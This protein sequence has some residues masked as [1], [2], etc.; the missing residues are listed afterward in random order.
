MADMR[1]ILKSGGKFFP[2][3]L[4]LLPATE[5][6]PLPRWSGTALSGKSCDL[7]EDT[8]H[9]ITLLTICFS[10]YAEPQV[11]SFRV[12]Y[13]EQY[14]PKTGF[15]LID[16]RP[17]MTRFKWLIFSGLLR[18]SLLQIVPNHLRDTFMVVYRPMELLE[19]LQV[20]NHLGA[21][22]Y[23]ID[24]EGRVRWKASGQANPDELLCFH[25]AVDALAREQA[26]KKP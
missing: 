12:P 7:L 6:T 9:K 26:K 5:A 16:V 18:R 19:P 23:L 21:Y 1:N 4:R 17:L 15:Q 22:V 2:A 14:Q 11:E 20:P 24:G 13:L 3:S 10:A 8:K 25:K